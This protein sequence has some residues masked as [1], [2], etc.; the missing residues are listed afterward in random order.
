MAIKAII[1]I[2][3]SGTRFGHS[4]PKQF[5]NLSGKKVYMHTVQTFLSFLDFKEIILVTH[6]NWIQSIQEE[7][8][9]PRVRIIPGGKSR[10]ESSYLGLLA[11]GK[12][13]KSV[14]IH[15]GA[16]PLLSKSI[17]KKHIS[18]LNNYQAINTCIPSAD[19]IVHTQNLHS[20]DAIPNRENYM[21]G[22]TP[23]SFV[24][25]LIL[26]AHQTTLKKNAS[27][28]CSLVLS[29][30]EKIHIVKGS[31]DNIKIT[32][33]LD[34]FIAEQ[35]LRLKSEPIPKKPTSL[36]GKIFA[37]A[38]GTG[39]VGTALTHLL[40]SEGARPLPLSRSASDYPV[41]LTSAHQT[42]TIFEKIYEKYGSLDGLI[43][44]VGALSLKPFHTLTTDEIDRF[45]SHNLHSLLYP[46]RFA[47]L[48]NGGHIVNLSSSS[49]SRGRKHY[50]LYSSAK[51]AV[52]N[53]TQGLAEERPDLQINAV[54]PGRINTPLRRKNF[55][56]ED[57]NILLSPEKVAESI[58]LLLKQRNT[59]GSFFEIR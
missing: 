17:L 47:R 9:D 33:L 21:R 1:L 32:T 13:T 22:Q 11:C 34:L 36:Q 45:I 37:I 52:L 42:K 3:G 35:L 54:I 43:N 58:C 38:G 59:T 27:D 28:D 6:P 46:C 10:Q 25:P 51:A 18:A 7:L 55:P 30:G 57:P 26:K 15:D 50:T 2:G 48:K 44:C 20:I 19:T 5:L 29:M 23:Q 40:T 31:E 41:D 24:Y 4:T 14:V 8:K 12:G 49:Y 39:G 53:F 16:R 56:S